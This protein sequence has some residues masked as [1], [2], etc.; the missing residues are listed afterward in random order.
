MLFKPFLVDDF[1]HGAPSTAEWPSFTPQQRAHH[2]EARA[3]ARPTLYSS[4]VHPFQLSKATKGGGAADSHDRGAR[5]GIIPGISPPFRRY[6]AAA[7]R[8]SLG[9]SAL[10]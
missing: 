7:D 2:A 5:D 1:A 4:R 3:A 8:T 9:G 10:G 6:T